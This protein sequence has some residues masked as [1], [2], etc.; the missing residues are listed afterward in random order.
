MNAL[1]KQLSNELQQ[2]LNVKI[3][4]SL[5]WG[6]PIH[7]VDIAFK[8][9]LRTKMDILMKMMLI[10]LQKSTEA[11]IEELSDILLVDPLFIQDVIG[12]MHRGGLI[13]KKKSGFILT[14][15]GNEQ[16]ATGVFE[17]EPEDG[18]VEILYSLCHEKFLNEELGEIESA[19]IDH[20]RYIDEFND[21]DSTFFEET[22]LR[23][24]IKDREVEQVEGSVQ[25]VVTAI[26]TVAEIRLD[27]I[28]CIEFR[29]YN[30]VE[31]SFYARVWNTLSSQWDEQLEKQLNAREVKSWRQAYL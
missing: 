11:S 3:M 10:T 2:D 24:V 7:T 8:T 20:Y 31:D 28:P 19:E 5:L 27:W 1:K 29:L 26:G 25:K 18:S 17:H 4:D 14:E 22:E 30:K 15:A 16:L 21:W 9:V 13:E 12:K 6:L 23:E